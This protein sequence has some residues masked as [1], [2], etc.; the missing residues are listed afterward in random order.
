MIVDVAEVVEIKQK[1]IQ[2]GRVKSLFTIRVKRMN[3]E[4]LRLMGDL[5]GKL[6]LFKYYF[7]N[8]RSTEL[9]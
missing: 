8:S 5:S 1:E 9:E 2:I 3:L 7:K 6:S 4:I